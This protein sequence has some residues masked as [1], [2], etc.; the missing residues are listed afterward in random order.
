MHK[1]CVFCTFLST[2]CLWLYVE[3]LISL[4]L[5][6]DKQSKAFSRAFQAFFQNMDE[7]LKTRLDETK[8]QGKMRRPY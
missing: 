8:M 4:L 2:V 3:L 5:L 1:I 7:Q 6:I